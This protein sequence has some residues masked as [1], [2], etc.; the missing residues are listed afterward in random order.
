[1][2]VWYRNSR[3]GRVVQQIEPNDIPITSDTARALAAT[4]K[5]MLNTLDQS[6]RWVRT[7][8]PTAKPEKP[9]KSEKITELADANKTIAFSPVIMD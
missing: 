2:T 7:S 9:M 5:H 3:T 4:A 8:A 6:K 1:M